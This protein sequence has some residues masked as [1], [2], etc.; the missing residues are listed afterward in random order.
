MYVNKKTQKIVQ[1]NE[2]TTPWIYL[3]RV[4][5]WTYGCKET[6]TLKCEGGDNF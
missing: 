5:H 2:N 1:H 6:R 3:L 4:V